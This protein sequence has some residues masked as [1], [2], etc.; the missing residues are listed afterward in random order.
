MHFVSPFR[1]VVGAVPRIS[2]FQFART[3][4]HTISCTLITVPHACLK[5][6][7]CTHCK[8]GSEIEGLCDRNII[9]LLQMNGAIKVHHGLAGHWMSVSMAH[10]ALSLRS[11]RHSSLEAPNYLAHQ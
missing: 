4:L 7:S 9:L 10:G 6:L 3:I 11:S 8:G 1:I 5:S 2:F